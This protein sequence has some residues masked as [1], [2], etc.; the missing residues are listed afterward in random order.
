LGKAGG[1]PEP[2]EGTARR[3]ADHGHPSAR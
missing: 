3:R 1:Q 2:M